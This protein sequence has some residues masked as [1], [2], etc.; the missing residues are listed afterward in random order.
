MQAT[1]DSSTDER[2]GAFAVLRNRDFR[3]YWAGACVSFIGSWVQ[4]IAMG[5]LVYHKTGSKQDLGW[6]ALAGGLPTTA[7]MLF[8]GVIADRAN[9]RALVLTTQS[10]FAL[11]A[12]ALAWLTWTDAIRLWHILALAF[13]NGLIFAVDGPAR[14]AMIQDLAGP[15]DLAAAVALQSAAFNTARVVGPVVG[16]LLY[17]RFGAHLCFLTNGLS[18]AAVLTAILLIRTDLTRRAVTD[19]SV[20]AGFLEGMRHLRANRMMRAVVGMTGMCSMFAFAFYSTLMPA[21][22]LDSLGI[23]EGDR[24]YG[25]LFS[26]IGAGALVGAYLVGRFANAGRRG[27]LMAAGANLFAVTLLGLAAARSMPVA[28]ALFF[29]VGMA[30][31]AQL[32]TANTLTQSLAPDELRGRAVSVHMFAMAGLQPLGG[33][34]AGMIAQRYG[35]TGALVFGAAVFWA[36]SAAILIARPGVARLE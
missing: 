9:R 11:N 26:A 32:A 30:A 13:A 4:I 21:F 25:F 18:F 2:R 16:S 20:W 8:G 15:Q 24:R 31:I 22:A 5:L 29:F 19:A 12:F 34:L 6:V 17:S 36:A 23:A 35:V 14:Q 33:F 10:L 27:L 3:L 28:L 1:P 7:L